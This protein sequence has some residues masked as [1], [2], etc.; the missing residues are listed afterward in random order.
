MK[1]QTIRSRILGFLL[2]LTLAV[3][4]T[5]GLALLE[6][7][8]VSASEQPVKEKSAAEPASVRG[9]P[10]SA[11]V[12]DGTAD[13]SWYNTADKTFTLTTPEQL[14]GLVAITAPKVGSY[15][16]WQDGTSKASRAEGIDVDNFEGKTVK[17]GADMDLNGYE[18]N[19]VTRKLLWNAISD[20]NN[21]GA[22]GAGVS[23]GTF[24]KVGWEGTFD[25]QGHII[26]NMRIDGNVNCEA[27]FGGYQGLFSGI[28]PGGVI[29][30][31]GISSGTLFGRVCG[32]ICGCSNLDRT[33]GGYPIAPDDVSKWPVIENCF[34]NLR[35]TGN[36][37]GSRPSGGIFGGEGSHNSW[38]CIY[39][40]YVKGNTSN[41]QTA[42]GV[43]GFANGVI[44]G[45]Y[46]TGE[47]DN[48]Y[49][50][51]IVATLQTV[52]TSNAS[53][54]INSDIQKL[55]VKNMA[56]EG[57]C[58]N[59]YRYG[60]ASGT[61]TAVTT[62][63]SS[64]A[65][66][67]A[68][69]ATLGSAY[70][71][72]TENINDGYPILWWQAQGG[73]SSDTI[74]INAAAIGE[75]EEQKYSGKAVEPDIVVTLAG[76]ALTYGTDYIIKYEDNIQPGTAKVY[77]CG[78]GR[79]T[80]ITAAAEFKIKDIDLTKCN[81]AAIPAQ[82][83]YGA[84]VTPG[85]KVTDEA[86]ATLKEGIDFS[87]KYTGNNAAG[88]AT[89]TLAKLDGTEVE[90][91]ASADFHITDLPEHFSGSGTEEE[92]YKITNRYE[93]E[94]LAYK[95]NHGVKEYAEAHYKLTDDITLDPGENEPENDPIGIFSAARKPDGTSVYIINPFSGHFDGGGHTV[96]IHWSENMPGIFSTGNSDES[97]NPYY[98]NSIFAFVG[99]GS[100]KG[101]NTNY[102]NFVFDYT[103]KVSITDLAVAGT[104][105]A[106][107]AGSGQ[108]GGIVSY[109]EGSDLILK[110]L[111][112]KASINARNEIGGI[113]CSLH[114][115]ADISNC[116]NEGVLNSPRAAGIAGDATLFEANLG[117]RKIKFI[118]CHNKAD[119]TSTGNL[120]NAGIVASFIINCGD[121][122]I[123]LKECSN[124]GKITGGNDSA[125]LA[126]GR[127]G[128]VAGKLSMDA[129]FNSGD[130]TCS[131]TGNVNVGGLIAN[132][133][134][135][136]TSITN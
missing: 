39:N 66:L 77:A 18:A 22:G 36:G 38:C 64:E 63:F 53:K 69:A 14:A 34:T 16:A 32:G 87:V 17:L 96:T 41:G 57:T 73:S 46:N 99:A 10:Q 111:T 50:G 131:S 40:C 33:K 92:P 117:S 86:G 13:T 107:S 125:G 81:I 20:I 121:Y 106:N 120:Q 28:R 21:W 59:F 104:I 136:K 47:V 112:N 61:P 132:M 74:D 78:V 58:A 62:G 19:G 135:C 49:N 52:V 128:M 67:K 82:W 102:N 35:I 101:D 91:A 134:Y 97:Y 122:E 79:Y 113:V 30:N 24:S 25:G 1:T 42:G 93:M 7:S 115:V 15:D 56:L 70:T 85:L 43:A 23:G 72:D 31:L 44:A 109:A 55:F 6:T 60:D 26:S 90:G 5:P 11:A 65:Q 110:N 103:K 119:L 3:T 126:G 89:V 27:N 71:D 29:K 123:S 129:C 108:C 88:K 94:L 127:I 100:W 84:P 9:E 118:R 37:S 116:V 45:C 2:A 130:V 124:T 80:G 4:M 68:G 12:W 83:R 98:G 8:Q 76:E 48:S 95:V 105:E 114:T 51:S 133:P 75:I 54:L